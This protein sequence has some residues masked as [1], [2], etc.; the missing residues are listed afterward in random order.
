MSD[1]VQHF[2]IENNN[3]NSNIGLTLNDYACQMT[4]YLLEDIDPCWWI[5]DKFDQ[6]TYTI[7]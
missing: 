3:N 6:T 7:L 2:H 4:I 5:D 1:N